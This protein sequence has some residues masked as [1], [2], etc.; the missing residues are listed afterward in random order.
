MKNILTRYPEEVKVLSSKSNGFRSGKRKKFLIKE[1]V[2][3]N[4]EDHMEITVSP[5]IQEISVYFPI[6]K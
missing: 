5:F 1:I 4:K 6:R 3:N 2:K